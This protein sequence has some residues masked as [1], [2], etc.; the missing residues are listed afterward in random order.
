ML[1]RTVAAA[2]PTRRCW[3]VIGVCTQASGPMPVTC[4]PNALPS[5]ATW[6]S[7]SFCTR[8][9]SLSPALS[10][11]D[12]SDRGGLWPSTSAAPAPPMVALDLL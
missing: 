8:G 6:L 4:A 12:A 7:T 5:G 10:V 1:V 9:R 3:P 2:L 11:A